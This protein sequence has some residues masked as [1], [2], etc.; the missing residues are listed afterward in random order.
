MPNPLNI[1]SRM[2]SK[3][4][5]EDARRSTLWT[6]PW[7]WR[8]TEGLYVGHNREVWLYRELPL[9]PLQWED[10]NVR[11]AVGGPLATLLEELGSTS[12]DMGGGLRTLS[13]NREIHL[14]S[15]T[16]EADAEVPEGTPEPLADYLGHALDFL[17]PH[18][19]LMVG[20]KLRSSIV[21]TTS[22][23]TG[24][25]AV[26][27]QIKGAATQA[28][29]ES[30]PDVDSY[31]AD[32]VLV[33]GM[34]SRNGAR[35]ASREVLAQLEAWYNLGRTPDATISETKDSLFIDDFD[36][37]ELA[38]VMRF[39]NP[40]MYA[41]N[42]QWMLDASTHPDGPSVISVRGELEPA[43]VAR[44]RA[45]RSQ[46]RV[47][48]QMEEEAATG[49]LE[50]AENSQTFQ[51]A[52]SFENYVAGAR[53]PLITECSI[54]MARRVRE[55]DETYIDELRTSYGIE[56]KPL[57]HRQLAALDETL[58]CSDKRV[59]PFLQDVSVGMLAFAGLQGFS[60]LGDGLGVHVGLTDPDYTPC[61]LNPLGA[62]AAN[63]PP[64]MG[65]FGDPGS[66][67]T[68]LCQMIAT[69][70]ALAGMAVIFVNPKGFS[71]L[72]PF[73][74]LVGGQVVKMSTLES[75]P[76]YFDPF[77]YTEPEMAAEVAT[78]YILAV[79]RG[80]T[81]KQEL[82]LGSGLKRGAASG[83]R[84]VGEALTFVTDSEVR[85]M[86]LQQCE[87]S[88]TFALG[89]AHTPQAPYNSGGGLTLIEFDRKLDLPEKSVDPSSYKRE[90]RIALA[91]IRLVARASM[92]I[93]SRAGGG[94]FILDEAWTFLSSSEGLG[95]LQTLGREGRSQNILPVFATQR[96]ADL[97]REG[98]DME[99]YLSRVFVMKLMEEREAAA[100]LTLCGLEPSEARI[101]WLR[102]AGPRRQE[103]DTPG[104][105][106]LALHRDLRNRHSAV[107]VG[108]VPEAARIAFSTNP[109]E[110]AKRRADLGHAGE[111]G[112]SGAGD[113]PFQE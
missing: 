43:T 38:A 56:M 91:A 60:N 69:Q 72:S 67:K 94:V 8:D 68:F 44:S 61:Y 45:R 64:A 79:L 109:E 24:V 75:Q 55:A 20:V 47:L 63:L 59:N 25:A 76:G 103:G 10:P 85:E 36:R 5:S 110:Q 53:E 90:Q 98:V 9:A 73:A 99:G 112:T 81:E 77:R 82:Q 66:G 12:K 54:V 49:D 108:P 27:E 51:L 23:K 42:A 40:V 104:R 28:L 15:I 1:F 57:E 107:V 30:V 4:G 48:N 62:P 71:S 92:E 70:A 6:T 16:W 78:S 26:L 29:G 14:L 7:A 50:R 86:V 89:I 105:P 18:K 102:Q 2:S 87:G 41:P 84:C 100:A 65:V 22:K 19:T 88:A 21:P 3:G 37:L 83:A 113:A 31:E 58:P 39:D 97:V 101:A 35:V 33:A 95:M 32:R 93:L 96:V 17:I 46:R 34:L 13:R 111:A 106:A 74:E 80:L 11:L 52:Q